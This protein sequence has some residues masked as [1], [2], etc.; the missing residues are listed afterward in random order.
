MKLKSF[1]AVP[2]VLL[3]GVV[4][5]AACGSD[6]NNTS[7]GSSPKA[8]DTSSSAA[9]SGSASASGSGS[10][11]D[12]GQATAISC[13]KGTLQLAGS[14]AQTNAM[15][16]WIKAYQ[17]ACPGATI[18]YGGGGSGQGVQN[19]QD[20]TIDFAGSDFPLAAGD[21]QTKANDRCKTGPAINLPMVPGAIAVAY[22]VP[23]VKSLSLSADTVAGIFS[24][25][26][27]KWDDSAIKKDNPGV[28]LPSAGIQTFHR[29]DG[30][31]TSYNFSNYLANDAKS[32]WKYGANKAW[33]APGGQGE[34]GSASVAQGVKSTPGGIGYMEVSYADQNKLPFAKVGNAGGKLVELND[35]NSV[36]FL[37][38]ATVKGGSGSN[39]LPLT[40]DYANPA[41]DAYPNLL[42]TYEIV[43]SKGNPS[44]KVDLIK[45]F[46]TYIASD[47]GQDILP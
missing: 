20:G 23:G 5:L 6:N 22:N 47:K 15:S 7:S 27:T 45:D 16:E 43:C 30:S 44:N 14:T 41:A 10:A 8:S 34:K 13:A 42:V 19:F 31:G 36:N 25:K 26:I 9:K 12:T 38:K 35:T 46:L 3:A 4:T 1:V 28:S 37:S 24:G 40:F 39:D 33:P 29:S 2:S 11:S 32:A 18:N 21:E 17:T